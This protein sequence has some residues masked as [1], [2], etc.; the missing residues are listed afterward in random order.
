MKKQESTVGKCEALEKNLDSELLNVEKLQYSIQALN[1]QQEILSKSKDAAEVDLKSHI[2]ELKNS[3]RKSENQLKEINELRCQVEL[4]TNLLDEK[5]LELDNVKANISDYNALAST[6]KDL[7]IKVESLE[8]EVG[9][10]QFDLKEAEKLRDIVDA[11]CDKLE[12]ELH[13]TKSVLEGK[14]HDLQSTMAVG[15]HTLLNNITMD[16]TLI[17][18]PADLQGELEKINNELLASKEFGIKLQNE[19]KQLTARLEQLQERYSSGSFNAMEK[20]LSQVKEELSRKNIELAGLKT[21]VAMGEL[22]FKKKCE[23]L[24]VSKF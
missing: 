4:M 10:L 19:N 24:Q 1:E 13:D 12:A 6:N 21:D 9:R 3:L 23:V 11:E 14:G 7:I 18:N 5:K 16:C 17:P 8:V 15:Q 22:E 20:N 2:E